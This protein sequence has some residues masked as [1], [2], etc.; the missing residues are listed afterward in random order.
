MKDYE[1]TKPAEKDLSD[2]WGYTL[3]KWGSIQADRYVRRLEYCFS[4]IASGEITGKRLPDHENLR[5][6][7]CEHHY[8]FF[9]SGKQVIILRV[10]HEKMDFASRLKAWLD[11]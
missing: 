7:R 1:L 8:I 3:D 9:Q 4:Q 6:V 11:N 5:S 10:L 2:I